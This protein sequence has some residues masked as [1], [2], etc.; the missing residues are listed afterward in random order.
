MRTTFLALFLTLGLVLSGKGIPD[1]LMLF[2]DCECN[3]T[4]LKQRLDYVNHTVDPTSAQVNLF[5]VTNYLSNGG[6]VYD[7]SFKGQKELAGNQL[8]FKVA[9]TAVMTELERDELLTHRI[10]L[11]LAGFLAGTPYGALADINIAQPAVADTVAAIEEKQEDKKDNWNNWI[12]EVWANFK[13]QTESQ[14]GSSELR[15][16]F[17]ADRTTPELRVRFSPNLFYR[18]QTV[19]Q[20]DGTSLT[21]VRR[22]LWMDASVVKSVGDHW[23][24]G[25]FN[26][27]SSSTFRNINYSVWLAP[28]IEYNI[29]DYADVPLREFTVAY[30]L[31]WAHNQYTEETIFLKDQESLVRHAVDVDLRVRQRWGQIFVG[32]SGGNFLTDFSKNRLSLNGRANVRVIKGLSFNIG[33][34]YEIINDQISLPRGTASVEDI[35]LGQSQLATNFEADLSFGLSYTFGSLYNNVINTRL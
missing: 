7:L 24:V 32:V 22:D 18:N 29:F 23:S 3:K 34:G 14:R 1:R 8:T 2:V 4:L 17:E 9:T 12:F 27:M 30:R 31:G 15:L 20:S 21:A 10:K 13:V 26:S 25:L 28:A 33:G 5:I 11:G 19:T 16:G 35:L 6:R